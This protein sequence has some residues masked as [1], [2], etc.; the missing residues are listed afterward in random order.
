MA[1]P[2]FSA[3]GLAYFTHKKVCWG[4]HS[5]GWDKLEEWFPVLKQPIEYFF[6]KYQLNFL[7][8]DTEYVNID[9]LKL[10]NFSLLFYEGKYAL[11]KWCNSSSVA[12]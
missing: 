9:Y 2:N 10:K 12:K 11:Y 3:D 5:S 8:I 4:G 7:L 6:D 1:I